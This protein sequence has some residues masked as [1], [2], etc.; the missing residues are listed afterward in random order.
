MK[1]LGLIVGVIA[2]LDALALTI[3]SAT[4][5]GID[6]QMRPFVI[7]FGVVCWLITGYVIY[8]SVNEKH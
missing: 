1:R 5:P 3:L 2:N 7:I 6:E 8:L 4:M